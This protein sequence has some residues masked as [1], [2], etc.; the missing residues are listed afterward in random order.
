MLLLLYDVQR[1]RHLDTFY[2]HPLFQTQF[3]TS[4]YTPTLKLFCKTE[5]VRDRQGACLETDY[6]LIDQ[7]QP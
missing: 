1:I 2:Q 4:Q 5:V 3:N 7:H 6:L